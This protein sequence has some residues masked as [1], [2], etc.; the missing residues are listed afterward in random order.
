MENSLNQPLPTK[1]QASIFRVKVTLLQTKR[2]AENLFDKNLAR[3]S[4]QFELEDQPV[5]A[6]SKT[7]LWTEKDEREKFLLAGKI[8]N[9]RLAVKK[10]NG[11]EVSAGKTFSFWKHIGKTNRRKGYVAGRELREGCI[12]PNVGGG[13]CQL[14][15]ALY[16][17]ALKANFE[18]V[19][20]HAHTQIVKG[21]LAEQ[22]RDA[23][24]FWNYVDLRFKSAN[25]FRIEAK[26]DA[27]HLIV[28]FKSSRKNTK[29][30]FQISKSAAFDSADS[31]HAGNCAT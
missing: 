24:V 20:R 19:E 21:S 6:E 23:T 26:L 16:D 8:H 13:L 2:C 7:I 27:E 11:L 17:A 4:L 30:I 25:A 5:I 28:R 1:L 12:I 29:Q 22:G 14:S 3:L 18:I 10:L 31:N 15:N 9:L